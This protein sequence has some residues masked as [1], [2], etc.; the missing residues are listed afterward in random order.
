META[1]LPARPSRSGMLARARAVSAEAWAR[2]AFGALCLAVA[3]GILVYP[4]YPNYDS[5]YALLWGREV[6]DGVVP[7][8]EGFRLPTEHPLA[9]AAGAVLSLFGESGDRLWIALTFASFLALVAGVYRLGRLAFTPLVGAIAAVLLLSRFDFAFLA[10]RGYIDIPYMALVVWAVALETA[11]PRRGTPV[12]A[13]LTAAGLIRPEAWL[14]AGLYFLWMSWRATWRE[15]AIWAL[16]AAAAPLGW[17]AVDLVVTGDP[18]FS[19]HYTSD[20]AE[21]LGRSRTLSE[22]PGAVPGFLAHLVK[23]PVLL[24]GIAGIAI[25]VALVPRRVVWPAVL[26]V[27][28]MGT[29]FAIGVAGLSVIERYLIVASLALLI[30]AAVAIGGW[31]MLEPGSRLRRAWAGLAAVAVLYGVVSVAMHLDLRR[32]DD[33]LSFRGDAHAALT[34]ILED[35]RVREA[36]RCGPITLPNHKLVPDTRWIAGE[37]FERVRAR[38]APDGRPGRG[39]AIYV[40][41]RFAIFK[42]AFT[43]D[44]DPATIQVPPDGWRPI[45]RSD[46]YAAYARC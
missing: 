17:C 6:L 12:F 1:A 4:T 34:Q 10:A 24:A 13:L 37:P 39:V 3:V 2:A 41:S 20:S 25:A 7:H 43:S 21:D 18:L 5:Y 16:W 26:L 40:T 19:L 32:F 27:T 8:F 38:A 44:A 36:S 42:H 22:L 29:F 31:T 35:P 33:E 23:L 9:I 30:F 46:L 11:R 28:G 15:R 45:A 14:L